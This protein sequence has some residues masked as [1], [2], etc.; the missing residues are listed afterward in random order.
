MGL[1][2]GLRAGGLAGGVLE[3]ELGLGRGERRELGSRPSGDLCHLGRWGWR[4]SQGSEMEGLEATAVP[5][6]SRQ[7]EPGRRPG[8]TGSWK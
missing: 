3:A 4:A 6:E 5:Q 7:L 1:G 8:A 2:V